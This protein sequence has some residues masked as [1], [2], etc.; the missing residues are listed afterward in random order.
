MDKRLKVGIIGV[1]GI[2]EYHIEAYKS[3]PEVEL[4]AFCDINAETLKLKGEKHNI[5]RL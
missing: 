4:Y 1:G 3:N 5:T 2:S